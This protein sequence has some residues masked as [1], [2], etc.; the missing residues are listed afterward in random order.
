M[1]IEQTLATMDRYF[2]LMGSGG[3]F[4]ELFVEDIRWLMVDSGKEVHGRTAVHDY[5]DELHGRML[6][7]EQQDLV[8]T[9]EHAYLEGSAVN[10]DASGPGL[11]Y[12]LVYDVTQGVITD[13][14]CYGTLAALMDS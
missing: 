5:I 8:V 11:S 13:M 10:A 14:R 1:T 3:D 9:E 12:C 2:E 7:G 6:S 4:S